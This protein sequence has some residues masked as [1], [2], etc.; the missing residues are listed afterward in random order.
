MGQRSQ[1]F[2]KVHN[3]VYHLLNELKRS[4]TPL[5]EVEQKNLEKWKKALGVEPFT[6]L[7]YHHQWLYG[8]T[9]PALIHQLLYFY[10]KPVE[11]HANH[12]LN[13]DHFMRDIE[14]GFRRNEVDEPDVT[15]PIRRFVE[16]HTFLMGTY[17]KPW[18]GTRGKGL[19]GF[20]FLNL[21]EPEMREH[22]DHGDNNDGIVLVDA[23]EGKYAFM[24]FSGHEGE[25]RT[26]FKNYVPVSAETY[27]QAYYPLDPKKITYRPD[28]KATDEDYVKHNT[29]RVKLAARMFK[30]FPVLTSDEVIAM[31]PKM[32]AKVKRANPAK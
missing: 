20:R 29:K 17:R 16:F 8:I 13:M 22:F 12:P 10:K 5:T 21:E 3:P 18:I 31:F 26:L 2:I 32:S 27:V 24:T 25:D 7:A 15:V 14:I 19:E 30:S 9:F 28:P 11:Q 6:V 23:V 4:T 1:Q